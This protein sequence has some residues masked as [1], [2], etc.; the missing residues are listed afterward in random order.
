MLQKDLNELEK[1]AVVA[2]CRMNRERDLAGSNGYG[3]DLRFEP[4]EFL[5]QVSSGTWLDLCCG[6]GKA[7]IQAAEIS[8]DQ[9][10]SINITG[11]DLVDMFLPSDKSISNLD[12]VAA[13]LSTWAPTSRFDLITCVHGLHYIGDKVDLLLR[14]RSWLKPGGKFAAN[15]DLENIKCESTG[16]SKRILKWLCDNGFEYSKQHHLITC[17]P[18]NASATTEF[19][20]IGADDQAGPN[21]TGQPAVN[22]YYRFQA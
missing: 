10:L 22:S 16:G 13:S 14:A 1:S 9:N 21:Y 18:A 2:N 6:S 12:L 7:L 5:S 19:K 17:G 11:V 20:F 15:L 3:I 4:L 8:Q